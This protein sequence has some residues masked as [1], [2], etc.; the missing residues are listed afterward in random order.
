M[1]AV[2]LRLAILAALL[3]VAL[4]AARPMVAELV[5]RRGLALEQMGNDTAASAMY[6]LE[7]RL[8]PRSAKAYNDLGIIR[9]D[10][11]D[12]QGAIELYS[13][14]LQLDPALAAAYQNR[15]NAR[16]ETG[17][18]QG[19]IT[20]YTLAIHLAPHDFY[21]Y[22]SRGAAWFRLHDYRRSLADYTQALRLDSR[23]FISYNNRGLD[24]DNLADYR[25]AVADYDRA[26]DLDPADSLSRVNRGLD[27]VELGNS[28][29]PLSDFARVL[30]LQP[31]APN[32]AIQQC[33]LRD[34]QEVYRA[35][36]ADCSR[37]IRDAPADPIGYLNR[38][39]AEEAAGR[40]R[41]ATD[42]ARKA[43][44]L[45]GTQDQS[46]TLTR[47]RQLLASIR[48]KATAVGKFS[49][50]ASVW[51][52]RQ[53]A[54]PGSAIAITIRSFD[55]NT[56]FSI[57]WHEDGRIMTMPGSRAS[58]PCSSRLDAR[59]NGSVRCS[60]PREAALGWHGVTVTDSWGLKGTALVAVHR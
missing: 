27:L 7:L 25:G 46:S 45:A 35:A 21:D 57:S 20:D 15:A 9:D 59:G 6:R 19:A 53:E 30:H 51:L 5:H 23:D 54:T 14:A 48:A 50:P 31:S 42:D 60:I 43:S 33:W 18:V 1:P 28:H 13:R 58:K 8:N 24:R 26:L 37:G 47:A 10:H 12:P 11:R 56:H 55:P 36:I 17:D 38:A 4:S 34:E 41:D 29:E 40:Y 44:H 52:S 32:A 22:R 2:L 39:L 3:F 49:P 16:L